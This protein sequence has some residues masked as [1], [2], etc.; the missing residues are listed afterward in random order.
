MTG[1]T[2]K[3]SGNTDAI[4]FF[5]GKKKKQEKLDEQ[6]NQMDKM[7]KWINDK[8]RKKKQNNVN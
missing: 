2:C 1:K 6:I 5:S 4:L 7:D 8:S 3:A